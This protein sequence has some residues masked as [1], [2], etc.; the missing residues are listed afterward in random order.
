MNRAGSPPGHRAARPPF[1]GTIRAQ[2]A[3]VSAGVGTT[4]GVFIERA[5]G[6][7]L[8]DVDGTS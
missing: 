5:G 6:G 2:E 7:I 8:V 4:F 1:E 3:T